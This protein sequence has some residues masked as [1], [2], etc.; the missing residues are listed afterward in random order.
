MMIIC[1]T[2]AGFAAGIY[3]AATQPYA[4]QT[5]LLFRGNQLSALTGSYR[6]PTI[7]IFGLFFSNLRS[8]IH[9]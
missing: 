1:G 7:L 6:A 8:N 5:G 3:S 2:Y 4:F 9:G